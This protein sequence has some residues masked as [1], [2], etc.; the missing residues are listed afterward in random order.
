MDAAKTTGLLSIVENGLRPQA[1]HPKKVLIIGA[2]MAG[3]T[4]GYELQRAGHEMTILEATNR[5]GGRVLTIREPFSDGLYGEAGAMRLPMSHKLTHAYIKKF[6]LKTMPFTKASDKA[7]FYIN[8]IRQL[9]SEAIIDPSVLK[10]KFTS[11]N[12]N[13]TI[14]KR[15]EEFV[16]HTA[17]RMR[18][19]E[20]YWDEL[21]SQY[22]NI[23]VYEFFRMDGWDGEAITSFAV[24]EVME[25][26]MSNSFLDALQLEL[27]WV[28]VDM[29]QIAGGMDRLPN[30][31]LTKMK[32]HI[33]FG[34]EMVAIDYTSDSVTI[35]YQ[36]EDGP[37]QI[38]GDFAIIAIP[39]SVLRHVDIVKPFSQAKQAA[40]RQLHY[41]NIAKIFIQC[42]RRFWEEDESLFGGATVTDLPNRLI[43]YPDHGRETK[44]G[45]LMASYAYGEEADRWAA[46]SREERITRV[47]KHTAKIH[48]QIMSEFEVGAS[49][50]WGEDKYAGGACAFFQPG[51][52]ARLHESIIAPEGP[53]FFAGEHASLKH[54]W[55]EGAVESGLRAASE[56]HERSFEIIL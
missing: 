37:Q 38:T 49:K 3:L 23:S 24:I 13:Q 18:A 29:N 26:I 11:P 28:G 56:I 1:A 20:G 5:V 54:M 7:F 19:N 33:R 47:L 2:G 55:I 45:I 27:Q 36:N 31:F 42:R 32:P 50:V 48:P 41:E 34:S 9:R 35:H 17:E 4:A 30:A 44:K 21:T 12:K 25:A 14:L 53:V 40:I 39:F 8:G 16:L 6:G 43:F 10:L 15:W 22:G 52:P 51:Q 46:L